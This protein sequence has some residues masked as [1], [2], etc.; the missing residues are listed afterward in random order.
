[1]RVREGKEEGGSWSMDVLK[2]LLLHWLWWPRAHWLHQICPS[3]CFYATNAL[4]C[5]Y[6]TGFGGLGLIGSTKC[7]NLSQSML[8]CNECTECLLLHWL[9][10]PRA[11][12]LHQMHKSV[13]VD[14]SM[15]R[16][17]W[18]ACYSTG[19]GGLEL[20]GCTKCT[21]LSQSMLLCNEWTEMPAT[22][23]T[24]NWHIRMA[25]SLFRSISRNL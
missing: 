8:L 23:L 3:R 7:T 12:W 16:M 6:S 2:C 5:C 20:I 19:F 11:H 24:K 21:N 22:P 15:Q 4:K 14:A 1:M 18:N 13:P 17:H 10:W 9:W 25:S